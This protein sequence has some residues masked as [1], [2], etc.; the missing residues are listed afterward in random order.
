MKK[1]RALLALSVLHTSAI[2][3]IVIDKVT[4]QGDQ[5]IAYS[6]NAPHSINPAAYRAALRQ[7]ATAYDNDR[8]I[9]LLI[10][11]QLYTFSKPT[12]QWIKKQLYQRFN[13]Y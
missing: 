8:W 11:S 5:I 7:A 9:T 10:A 3:C 13:Q 2:L 12:A 1:H 4:V 6:H